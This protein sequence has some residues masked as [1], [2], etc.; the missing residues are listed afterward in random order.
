VNEQ[1]ALDCVMARLVASIRAHFELLDAMIAPGSLLFLNCPS[2]A[3]AE[4]LRVDLTPAEQKRVRLSWPG[5][6]SA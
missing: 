3:I 6:A 4:R 2:R 1:L 5:K